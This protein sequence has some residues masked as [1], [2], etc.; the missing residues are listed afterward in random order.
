ML[1]STTHSS[2]THC[3]HTTHSHHHDLPPLLPDSLLLPPLP[4]PLLTTSAY[5]PTA[6]PTHPSCNSS[7]LAGPRNQPHFLVLLLFLLL[8]AWPS[9]LLSPATAPPL[10]VSSTYRL[11]MSTR[12]ESGCLCR[13]CCCRCGCSSPAPPPCLPPP[14]LLPLPLLPPFALPCKQHQVRLSTWYTAGH[15]GTEAVQ[16]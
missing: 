14:L 6:A 2:N 15:K 4:P 9:L 1:S 5:T 10:P 13:C 12:Q 8:V 16:A 3:E 11:C 7:S